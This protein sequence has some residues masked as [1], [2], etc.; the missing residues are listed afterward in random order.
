MAT[1][2]W[3]KH[4]NALFTRLT[5]LAAALIMNSLIVGA[6]GYLFALQA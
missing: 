2:Y 5:A 6:V 4:M 1:T 3:E